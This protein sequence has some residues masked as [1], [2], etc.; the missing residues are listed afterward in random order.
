MS[1]GVVAISAGDEHT[2]ALTT[3][4]AAKCWG[5]GDYG[6]LGNG[7]TSDSS[8]PVAVSGMSSGVVAISAGAFYTCALMTSGAAKCWG[9]GD[10]GQL[11]N[12]ATSDSSIPVIVSNF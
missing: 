8:I 3:S 6:Q 11:G 9:R 12:G 4:G 1:S 5:R 7:A 10:N 2:C